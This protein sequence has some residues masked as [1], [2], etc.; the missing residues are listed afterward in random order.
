MENSSEFKLLC[1]GNCLE[2]ATEMYKT[3]SYLDKYNTNYDYLF[4]NAC[5]HGH[6]EVAKWLLSICPK[7]DVLDDDKFI[8][9][10]ICKS[11]YLDILKFLFE[12]EPD[13]IDSINIESLFRI[14]IINGNIDII[15]W[16][17]EYRTSIKSIIDEEILKIVCNNGYIETAKLILK[18]RPDIDIHNNE[19]EIFIS[20][21]SE[22]EK[23]IILWLIELKPELIEYIIKDIDN[24][25][26]N[27]SSINFEM[28]KWLYELKPD[29]YPAE[30]YV[31]IFK[32]VLFRKEIKD[33]EWLFDK[34]NDI[35][36]E[37]IKNIYLDYIQHFNGLDFNNKL[38]WLKQK[39]NIECLFDK[40]DIFINILVNEINNVDEIN[41][42]NIIN[43]Y[44]LNKDNIELH[45]YNNIIT[46]IITHD[47][48]YD[49]D[50]IK[51][52]LHLDEKYFKIINCNDE[53]KEVKFIIINSPNTD[54]N[55]NDEICSICHQKECDIYTICEHSYH[56]DCIKEWLLE[57]DTCPNCRNYLDIDDYFYV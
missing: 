24:L 8:F 39:F 4:Q 46:K 53:Y 7:I 47:D 1:I 23:D 20:S 10:Q 22:Y 43:Y 13:I 44:E 25:F 15:N 6:L 51:W 49:F 12:I 18:I 2:E 42:N 27:S 3:L 45:K 31:E 48:N 41:N 30:N 11:G 38:T 21:L 52:Y 26:L 14:S 19:D 36:I 57:N 40:T 29:L 33:I 37:I 34:K 32:N 16:F 9:E 35:N 5:L 28:T 54:Y 56:F 55:K 50:L 17:I